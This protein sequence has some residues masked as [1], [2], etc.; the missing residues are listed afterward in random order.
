M[1]EVN[2]LWSS[3]WRKLQASL[4][5]GLWIAAV[6]GLTVWSPSLNKG[7]PAD[8]WLIRARDCKAPA[9]VSRYSKIFQ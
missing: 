6:P 9:A 3:P 5:S 2:V 7:V 1:S 8:S 4:A